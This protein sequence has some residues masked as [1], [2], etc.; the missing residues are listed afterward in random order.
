MDRG[1]TAA[2]ALGVVFAAD[3]LIAATDPPWLV[4]GALDE[5]AHLATAALVLTALPPRPAPWTAGF[6]AGSVAVDAD[7][8]PLIPARARITTGTRRPGGHSLVT[9]L[10]AGGLALAL[11]GA[12]RQA[13]AGG[14]AG[15][16]AHFARDVA[17]A[18]GVALARPLSDVEVRV[19]WAAYAA[20]MVALAGISVRRARRSPA[21]KLRLDH[22]V[23][24]VSDWERSNAFY[25]EV[26][27]AELVERD[28]G[29][30][31]HY[32]F[33]GQQLNVH[34]PGS[35]PR[36]VALN[37][38]GPGGADLCF[39]W[40]GPIE[41]AL[42]HLETH[43]VEVIEG[44]VTRYGARGR[45]TSVYFHDPDGSLLELISYR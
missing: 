2:A 30:P 21:A 13:A 28:G 36:P 29:S 17:S 31:R 7:H 6:L 37:E 3:A 23:I 10:A 18:R 27:G 12:G 40:D 15:V 22:A 45:G 33:G 24:A 35:T 4:G 1:R 14:A 11:R 34:G 42:R 44:P 16:C 9:A 26:L 20:A 32:R 25:R 41:E 8:I 43:G 39:A 19:P 38:P 5:P